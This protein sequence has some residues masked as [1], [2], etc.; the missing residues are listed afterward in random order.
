MDDRL[1]HS[2]ILHGITQDV[3]QVN[4][5][6]FALRIERLRTIECLSFVLICFSE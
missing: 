2:D 4:I 6:R 3:F 1:E 5:E